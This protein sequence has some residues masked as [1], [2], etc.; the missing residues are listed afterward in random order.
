MTALECT[1]CLDP[2]G[3]AT[4]SET[5]TRGADTLAHGSTSLA[6]VRINP[7]HWRLSARSTSISLCLESSD[8]NSPCA[9]GTDAGDE[10]EL[11]PGYVGSGYCRA[12]HT[13]PLCQVCSASDYYFDDEAAMECIE[14]PKVRHASN[15]SHNQNLYHPDISYS[16]HLKIL[17]AGPREA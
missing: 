16:T 13:G 9:G 8:G 2:V 7:N 10:D 3:G 17:L 14:C 15:T 4:C 6:T 12:G 1:S 11:K 5:T